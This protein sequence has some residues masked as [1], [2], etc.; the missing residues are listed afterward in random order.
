MRR[1]SVERAPTAPRSL[2]DGLAAARGSIGAP[3]SRAES[4]VYGRLEADL[5]RSVT[6]YGFEANRVAIREMVSYCYEQGIIRRLYH[7][8]ELFLLHDS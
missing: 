2:F 7:A 6:S 8:E 3:A 1:G 4:E 5:G